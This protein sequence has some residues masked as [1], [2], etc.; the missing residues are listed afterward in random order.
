M[1]QDADVTLLTKLCA[2]AAVLIGA[3]AVLTGSLSAQSTGSFTSEQAQTGGKIFADQCSACHGQNLEGISGPALAGKSFTDKWNGETADDL[4]Y[5][6]STQMPLTA[7]GSLKPDEYIDLV[8]FILSR[9]G[10]SPGSTPLT[11]D[12]LKSIK[13]GAQGG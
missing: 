10:F 6:V 13:F 7:P 11:P 4:H 12:K 1:S 8:A 9:N 2:A 3:S 5:I